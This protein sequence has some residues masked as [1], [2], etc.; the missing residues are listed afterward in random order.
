LMR[1]RNEGI[2]SLREPHDLEVSLD[3][4]RVELFTVKP[5]PR[6]MSDQSL[7]ANLK[8]RIKVTAG[9]HKV[10]VAFLKKP[11]SLL[12]TERQPLNVHFNFYRHPRIGPA[13]YQVS[14]LGPFEANGPGDTPSRRRVF[15]CQPN[16]PADEENCARQIP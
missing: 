11:S 10:S 15:V 7:D 6:G 4:A 1:D 13:V 2:E 16:G 3:R 14:I 8:T 5:P 12:E 9:P